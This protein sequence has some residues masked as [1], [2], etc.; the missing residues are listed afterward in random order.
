MNSNPCWP[1]V[2]SATQLAARL[3]ELDKAITSP[4]ENAILAAA[5]RKLRQLDNELAALKR[6]SA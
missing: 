3:E 4:R 2:E 1:S 6:V 5:A